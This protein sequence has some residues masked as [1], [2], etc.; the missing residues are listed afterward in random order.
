MSEPELRPPRQCRQRLS[1]RGAAAAVGALL[2]AGCTPGP[3][4][5]AETDGS[6]DVPSKVYTDRELTAIGAAVLQKRGQSQAFMHDSQSLRTG[7]ASHPYQL[8]Q[9]TADPAECGVFHPPAM[10]DALRDLSMNFASGGIPVAGESSPTT[11]AVF[12]IKSAPNVK[13]AKA[14]F[15]Y[16]RGLMARCTHFDLS[17]GP[18]TGGV[19]RTTLLN[20]PAIGE[21]AYAMM[22]PSEGS[23]RPLGG[24]GLRVLSGTVSI[25]PGLSVSPLTSAADAQPALDS[26]ATIARQLIEEATLNPPTLA[27]PPVNARTPEQLAQLLQSVT[28]PNGAKADMVSGSV[29]GGALGASPPASPSSGPCTFSESDYYSS[30]SGSTTAP[31][32]IP[33][34]AKTDYLTI[35]LFSMPSD[36][37]LPYPFDRRAAAL[38]DCPSITEEAYSTAGVSS[39]SQWTAVHR[40]TFNVAA[41]SVYAI[42]HEH[43][44]GG[45]WHLLVGARRGSLT[46]ELEAFK[47]EADLQHGADDLAAVITQVFAKAGV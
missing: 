23:D 21:K 7:Y 44:G 45:F 46:V 9:A 17:Y 33:G 10:D 20:A 19:Y 2:L 40:P 35:R 6:S 22:S 18:G 30:L 47:S 11:T 14:D 13:L 29:I 8:A 37:A 39:T 43:P 28:G 42:A 15:E 12:T 32:E 1:R 5:P 25:N 38:K 16:D 4:T 27:P 41:D 34:A 24:V 36:A 26:M 3:S 31:G